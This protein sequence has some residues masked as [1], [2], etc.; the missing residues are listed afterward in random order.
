MP[1]MGGVRFHEV[2]K[3]WV[4]V[5]QANFR[6]TERAWFEL[7]ANVVIED[8]NAF[9]ADGC[10]R[11]QLVGKIDF[12][13]VGHSI[14]ATGHVELFTMSEDSGKRLMRYQASFVAK[15]VDYKMIG[16]KH[17][18]KSAG[19]NVWG[20]TTTLFTTIARSGSDGYVSV[21]AGVIRLSVWQGARMLLTLRGTG[22]D[23][24]A[25]RMN[26]VFRF[27]QF[28]AREVSA[29]YLRSRV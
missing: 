23:S 5:P 19:P 15:G 8:L 1:R 11:G 3:G 4:A 6:D 29:A 13:P 12:D 24:L 27:I 18:S 17:V 9:L 25:R 7:R 16:T 22:S 26:A 14:P 20:H 21:A 2:M 10:H 28:F